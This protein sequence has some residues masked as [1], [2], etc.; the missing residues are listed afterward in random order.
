L[1]RPWPYRGDS[2][3]E[4]DGCLCGLP[5]GEQC[6]ARTEAVREPGQVTPVA[7]AGEKGR[8]FTQGLRCS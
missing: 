4:D 6:C 8:V 5:A 7:L 1:K 2:L 3:A